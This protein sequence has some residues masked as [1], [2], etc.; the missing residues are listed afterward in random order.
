[1]ILDDLTNILN[2]VVQC[3]ENFLR[4]FLKSFESKNKPFCSICR[5]NSESGFFKNSE[6]SSYSYLIISLKCRMTLIYNDNQI[7]NREKRK[8]LNIFYESCQN[9][10]GGKELASSKAQPSSTGFRT[11][12]LAESEPLLWLECQIC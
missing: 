2:P 8:V 5:T 12:S 3:V 7:L 4:A 10:D 11:I 9:N 1:M 6:L